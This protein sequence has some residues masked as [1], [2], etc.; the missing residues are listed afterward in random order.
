MQSHVASPDRG[1]GRKLALLLSSVFGVVVGVFMAAILFYTNLPTI[2]GVGPKVWGRIAELVLF[3]P[4]IWVTKPVDQALQ[5][6]GWYQAISLVSLV[7]VVALSMTYAWVLYLL[8]RRQLVSRLAAI[9]KRPR[10]LLLGLLGAIVLSAAARLEMRRLDFGREAARAAAA[11]TA[12]AKTLAP[13]PGGSVEVLETKKVAL[14][15]GTFGPSLVR[16]DGQD[17]L[18]LQVRQTDEREPKFTVKGELLVLEARYGS[19]P[20]LLKSIP[21]PNEGPPSAEPRVGQGRE[22]PAVIA[23]GHGEQFFLLHPLDDRAEVTPIN[24]SLRSAEAFVEG[25]TTW[26]VGIGFGWP[27]EESAS[28]IETHRNPNGARGNLG[29]FVARP[30]GSQ[31]ILRG[32]CR[33]FGD[34]AEDNLDAAL[35]VDGMLFVLGAEVVISNGNSSRIH[36]L[37]FDTKTERWAGLET[38]FVRSSFT[39]TVHPRL[40]LTK[41]GPVALWNYDGGAQRYPDDGLWA[42]APGESAP[43]HL[44]ADSGAFSILPE[45]NHGEPLLAAATVGDSGRLRWFQRLGGSWSSLGETQVSEPIYTAAVGATDPFVLWRGAAP[46]VVNALFVGVDGIVFQRL[47]VAG[48]ATGR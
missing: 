36:L 24:L 27:G 28:R 42:R 20:R 1:V 23:G 30:Q 15:S 16:R 43:Y 3:A 13:F 32:A 10:A 26:F 6:H 38:L 8:L 14:D 21:L 33:E 39:S 17:P 19:S 48:S 29:V 41:D 37:R 2:C 4:T 9:A 22:T 25:P 47:R 31:P 18:V 40:I 45:G 5:L 34:H 44:S 7:E 46:S 11:P 12:A 35:G